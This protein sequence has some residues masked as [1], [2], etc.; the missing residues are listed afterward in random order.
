MEDQNT[1]VDLD[2]IKTYL[3]KNTIL[4]D[5]AS[6]FSAFSD[7]T[8]IR[9]ISALAISDMCVNDLVQTLNLN[10]STVSHQLKLLRDA[11]IVS[12]RRN[13]KQLYYHIS[14]KYVDE[15]MLTGTKQ[16]GY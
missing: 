5:M 16:L 15:I 4:N 2:M 8:R 14:N 7:I 10:Q 12:Y 9:M 6:F 11:K 1:Q 13:G 3:P